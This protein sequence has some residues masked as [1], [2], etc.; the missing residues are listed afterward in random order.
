MA[1]Q[2]SLKDMTVADII[3]HNCQDQKTALLT[4]DHDGKRAQIYMMNGSVVHAVMGALT[5]EAVVFE[6]LSWV[7]GKF[8]LEMGVLPPSASIKRTWS[9]LLLEGAKRLD[10][11]HP[12]SGL[13]FADRHIAGREA[14]IHET[15]KAFV[16]ASKIFR[17]VAITDLE[18]NIQTAQLDGSLDHDLVTAA[19]TAGQNFGRRNLN[20]L[21]LGPFQYMITQGETGCQVVLQITPSTL[22]LGIAPPNSDVGKMLQQLKVVTKRLADYV[23]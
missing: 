2:G 4:V 13:S 23:N 22:F 8:I 3:Q 17:S 16:M 6:T 11:S 15:L 9:S 20:L 14:V 7:D 19:A 10:E 5:G 1:M 12:D 21:G 18:G